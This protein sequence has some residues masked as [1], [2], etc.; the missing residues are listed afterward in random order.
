M[1]RYSKKD[2][3]AGSAAIINSTARGRGWGTKMPVWLW[4]KYGLHI[5]TALLLDDGMNNAECPCWLTDYD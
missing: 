4:G 2:K 3:V 5:R 1:D